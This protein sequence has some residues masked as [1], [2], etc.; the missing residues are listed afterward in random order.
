MNRALVLV[1]IA[2]GL[3]AAACGNGARAANSSTSPGKAKPQ[4]YN[5]T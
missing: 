4:N 5:N 3:M 1:V 2:A